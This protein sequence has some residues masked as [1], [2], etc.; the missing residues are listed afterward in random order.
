M[1]YLMQLRDRTAIQCADVEYSYTELS[2]YAQ[3]YAEECGTL[4]KNSKVAIFAPNSPE[5]IFAF[6][7]VM[8]SGSVAVPI[9]EM[10]TREELAYVLADARPDV[11]FTV[12]THS[13]LVKNAMTDSDLSARVIMMEE[14]QT[15]KA[16]ERKP[17]PIPA[18]APDDIAL[19]I[20]TSGTSGA[21]KGVMLSYRNIYYNVGAVSEKV[22]IFDIKRNVMI[23]LP[24]H[25]AFPLMGSLIAPIY[26]GATV[27]IAE[28][29]TA[30]IVLNTLNEGKISIII[31]VPRLYDLLAKGVMAKIN[32]H[33][34]IR[35]L[36]KIVDAIGWQWLSKLV[37]NTV[38]KKF[39]GNIKYLVSGGAALSRETAQIYKALGFY[40][41]EGYGMTETAPMISFT[42][43]GRRK[44]GYAGDPLPGIDVRVDE[45]G[46]I[47]V[48]GDNVM[49]GYYNREEETRAIIKDGWLHTGDTGILDKH[50]LKLTGRIK[51]IIVTSNGKNINPEE[52]ENILVKQYPCIKEVAVLSVKGVLSAIIV[53]EMNAVRDAASGEA[54]TVV[55][56]AVL[57]YNKN[58]VAYKHIRKIHVVSVEL[59]KTKLGKL[60][61]FLL[62]P[63]LEKVKNE[64][65]ENTKCENLGETFDLLKQF[66]ESETESVAKADSH[67]EIDLAMDSLTRVALMAYVESTFGVPITAGQLEENSTLRQL[68]NFIE[69]QAHSTTGKKMSW[70]D[71]LLDRISQVRLNKPGI[72]NWFINV[73]FKSGMPFVYKIKGYGK[74]KIPSDPC[75]MVAN[76][77]SYMDA[78][79]I[80]SQLTVN[81]ARNTYFFAKAKHWKSGF[82]AF[83]AKKNNVILMDINQNV[84]QAL[85]QVAAALMRG[86]NV[87]IF[88]EGTRS[89]NGK[90]SPFKETFAIISQALSVKVVPVVVEGTECA[91]NRWGKMPMLKFGCPIKVRFLEPITPQSYED[92]KSIRD[93]VFEVFKKAL[94]QVQQQV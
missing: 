35:I 57:D 15:D 25:H 11:I 64:D 31:G 84:T 23:L 20:Y 12:L 72:V 69:N 74:E 70:R 8:L 32:E 78:P 49:V 50:G 46:E 68:S 24:L 55:R 65:S 26:V 71:I 29:L 61:R 5:W 60:Q 13:E 62:E 2:Q 66:V 86:K 56:E 92:S 81:Q 75:I 22:H 85:Q 17:L 67:F 83:M 33:R 42:R 59:P 79:S 58:A 34:I 36:Y 82:M 41:L 44:I 51:D 94:G 10:S 43:P 77:R 89:K 3:C 6:Y 53:P 48:R 88:P 27:V 1:Q 80:I 52:I 93:K 45:N 28:K 18:G 4:T 54:E 40:V 39:G 76:H 63:L 21:A 16:C 7:G 14:V 38:H 30:D 9:D 90:L 87:I 19:I 47:C 37:F 91:L 73:F